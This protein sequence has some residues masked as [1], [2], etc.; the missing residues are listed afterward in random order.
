MR[1][2][3]QF[4]IK[5]GD[6]GVPGAGAG[7]AQPPGTPSSDTPPP[8]AAS[9]ADAP[10][11]Y[12][13]GGVN[14]GSLG[15]FRSS[16]VAGATSSLRNVEHAPQILE[17][18]ELEQQLEG[19]ASLGGAT[20]GPGYG[21]PQ[22]L[23]EMPA[24]EPRPRSGEEEDVGDGDDR[25]PTTARHGKQ[26]STGSY[27]VPDF[28]SFGEEDGDE[29]PPQPG[30]KPGALRDSASGGLHSPAI[31]LPGVDGRESLTFDDWPAQADNRNSLPSRQRHL[32]QGQGQD[33]DGGNAG[34]DEDDE[35]AKDAEMYMNLAGT[36]GRRDV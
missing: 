26:R 31:R 17:Q 20:A 24:D 33:G 25:T 12:E 6:L 9:V 19:M 32:G 35:W 10:L 14:R 22:P 30:P 21:H 28:G 13:G 11:A 27:E 18:R 7:A 15:S 36:L 23:A 2:I 1:T 4:S 34:E 8:A 5:G 16:G 3:A 29:R